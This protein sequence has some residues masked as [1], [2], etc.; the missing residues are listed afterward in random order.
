MHTSNPKA[1]SFAPRLKLSADQEPTGARLVLE[2]KQRQQEKTSCFNYTPLDMLQENLA[3]A[4]RQRQMESRKKKKAQRKASN[5]IRT[6]ST[7][8]S[9]IRR[10]EQRAHLK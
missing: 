1:G 5:R 2:K 4:R 7:P 8:S 10:R 6:F 3:K 9:A